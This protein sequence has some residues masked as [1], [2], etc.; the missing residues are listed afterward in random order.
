MPEVVETVVWVTV[1]NSS[2]RLRVVLQGDLKR[3]R[4]DKVS[5]AIATRAKLDPSGVMLM[6]GGVILPPSATAYDVGLA[7]GAL[8]NLVPDR[9]HSNARAPPSGSRYEDS[10]R[11][12]P[13][14]GSYE[15]SGRGPPPRSPKEQSDRP[16]EYSSG[17]APPPGSRYEDSGRGAPPVGSYENSGRGPPPRSPK[18]QSDW[19]PPQG[20]S[21][22]A[23]GR[24][25]IIGVKS[26]RK[27]S[28]QRPIHG[29]PKRIVSGDSRQSRGSSAPDRH[30]GW[31][32]PTGLRSGSSNGRGRSPSPKVAYSPAVLPRE[33]DRN[34]PH[35]PPSWKGRSRDDREPEWSGRRGVAGGEVSSRREDWTVAPR[36]QGDQSLRVGTSGGGGNALAAAGNDPNTLYLSLPAGSFLAI[37]ADTKG[38]PASPSASI[39]P[40]RLWDDVPPPGER[41]GD[42]RRETS[43]RQEQPREESYMEQRRD[44]SYREQRRD[45]S[46]RPRDGPRGDGPRGDGYR[47]HDQA[48]NFV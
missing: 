6:S 4:V 37:P 34:S 13:P 32:P 43:F 31:L 29:S 21:Y 22:E 27:S 33:D 17:R 46:Y 9:E 8:L 2:R 24:G 35:R 41:R 19:G 28:P 38:R 5:A 3:L 12:A 40:T 26:P 15:G 10:G 14:V 11:G 42:E 7:E 23:P 44:E 48:S 39:P 45:E 18:E 30:P 36:P 47:F 1:P 25:S 20:L 16:R